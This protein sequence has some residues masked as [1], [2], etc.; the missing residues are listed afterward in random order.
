M[1]IHEE[2]D[3]F[4]MS[5]Y[6]YWNFNTSSQKFIFLLAII[7]EMLELPFQNLSGPSENVLLSCKA[8]QT[9]TLD[10]YAKLLG[11]TLDNKGSS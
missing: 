3:L 6:V 1:E 9:K 4:S 10:S 2:A 7:F 11:T 5:A 8:K